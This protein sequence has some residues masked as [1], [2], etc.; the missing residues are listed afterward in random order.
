MQVYYVSPEVIANS[1]NEK[2]DVWSLGVVLYVIITAQFP[3][4]GPDE[5]T[6]M[7]NITSGKFTTESTLEVIQYQ[8][9]KPVTTSR[10]C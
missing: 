3:F 6:I 9:F 8:P 2:C 10:I 4:D 1:Y 5:K 7:K